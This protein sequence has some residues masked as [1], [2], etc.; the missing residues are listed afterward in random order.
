M[1]SNLSLTVNYIILF[2]ATY[3]YQLFFKGLIHSLAVCLLS[4]RGY[5]SKVKR[6]LLKLESVKETQT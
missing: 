6:A 4:Y 3:I 2:M 5:S 1:S